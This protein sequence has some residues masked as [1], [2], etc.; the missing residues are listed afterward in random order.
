MS[1]FPLQDTFVRGEI[2]PR[3]HSRASLDLY[4]AGL[5]KCVNFFTLPHGGIRK[6]G[7]TYFVGEVKDS[8]KRTRGVPFIFSADQAYFLE[9]GNQ[10]LRVYAYGARVGTVEVTTPYLEA[11][12]P[13]LMFYQSADAMWI[14]HA[15]YPVQKLTRTGHTTWSL[16]E[17][18]I[19]EGPY[20]VE[21][22]QGTTLTLALRA[23][24]TPTMTSNTA[25]SGTV[26]SSSGASNAYLVFDA[27]RGQSRGI[28]AAQVN[29]SNTGRRAARKWSRTH[30][31]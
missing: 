28:S 18:V 17:F 11:D 6:L 8:S 21:E 15:S 7:G 12:L 16:A 3:L 19:D 29:G 31:G 2:S 25:P 23:S 20:D 4:R 5:S 22:T 27:T 1:V 30:G 9:F 24:I 13:K 14:T 26:S 10:Y